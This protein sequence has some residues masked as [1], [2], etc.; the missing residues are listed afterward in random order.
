MCEWGGNK[1][2]VKLTTWKYVC[3]SFPKLPEWLIKKFRQ[4]QENGEASSKLYVYDV[5]KDKMD[6]FD[7]ATGQSS[8]DLHA[9]SEAMKE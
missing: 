9:Y 4:I 5:E 8:D 3:G 1:N 6:N 2:T 7:F